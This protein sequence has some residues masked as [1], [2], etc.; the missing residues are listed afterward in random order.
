MPYRLR[1]TAFWIGVFASLAALAGEQRGMAATPVV[2]S[3]ADTME[4]VFRDEPWN[5]PPAARLTVE[6][7]RNEVQGVQLVVAAGKRDIRSATLEVSDLAGEAGSTIP[8]SSVAWNIVGYVET[9]QPAYPVRKVGWWPDPL[10]PAGRFDVAAV[11]SSRCGSTSVFRRTPGRGCIA[12]ALRS[13]W[14]TARRS[15]CRWR[16]GCGTSPCPS[17]S[18]WRRVS[19]CGRR[20]CR[21]STSC[22]PCPSR[23]TSSGSTSAWT[24]GSA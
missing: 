5:R 24:T 21:S 17:S 14:P 13:G 9:E 6:A 16:S 12:A 4:K 23:C 15:P 2:L 10:L 11:R 18:T 1:F 20:S 7:A 8:K 3:S 19:C 22:P